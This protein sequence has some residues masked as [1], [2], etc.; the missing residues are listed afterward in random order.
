LAGRLPLGQKELLRGKLLV[1][2]IENRADGKTM[3]VN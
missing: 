3:R 2:G 1:N